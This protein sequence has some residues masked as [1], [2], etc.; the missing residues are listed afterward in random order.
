MSTPVKALLAAAL[1][2]LISASAGAT[3]YT[4]DFTGTVTSGSGVYDTYTAGAAVSGTYYLNFNACMAPSTLPVSQIAYWECESQGGSYEDAP[5]P[6]NAVF[7]SII[8]NASHDTIYQS[9]IGGILEQSTIYG[10]V[11]YTCGATYFA[12][13]AFE[14]E[15]SVAI[16][17]P[18]AVTQESVIDLL[19]TMAPM[20]DEN[21]APILVNANG[22]PGTPGALGSI[23]ASDPSNP[24]SELIFTVGSLTARAAPYININ[25]L[26]LAFSTVVPGTKSAGQ[27]ITVTNTGTA[28]LMISSV[29]LGGANVPSFSITNGC[30]GSLAAGATC[31]INAFFMPAGDGAKSASVNIAS[32]APGSPLMVSLTGTGGIP[33]PAIT[34]SAASLPF[35]TEAL[36]LTTAAQNLILTNSGS[37]PLTVSSVSVAGANPASFS[38]TNGCT[39]SVAVG[40]TCT[41]AVTFHPAGLGAKAGTVVIDSNVADSP[42]V[43][44]LSGTGAA[45]APRITLT[46]PGNAFPPGLAFG[47]QGIGSRSAPL[48]VG[49]KNTGSATLVISSVKLGGANTPSFAVTNGCS[50]SLAVN[51][52]CNISTTFTPGGAGLKSADLIIASNASG[53]ARQIGITGT[54]VVPAPAIA[55]SPASLMFNYEKIGTASGAQT[56]TVTNTGSAAL[57]ISSV[58]L[59]GANQPAFQLNNGCT[60]PVA[61]GNSC[62]ITVTFDSPGAG[63][64]SAQVTITSNAAGSPTIVAMTG[65]SGS[66]GAATFSI[67]AGFLENCAASVSGGLYCWG[68]N[69]NGQVGNGTYTIS[70]PYGISTPVAVVNL[71]GNAPIS[72][73][74]A[75]SVGQYYACALT[76]AGT[77]DCW[78]SGGD[79]LGNYTVS[80]ETDIPVPV[81]N[82]TGSAPLAGI[83]ELAAGNSNSCALT[84]AGTVWCWGDDSAGGL[85]IGIISANSSSAAPQQVLNTSGN[86]PLS[87]IIAISDVNNPCALTNGG[88][89]YCWGANDLGQLGNNST[90]N[91]GLPVAVLNSSG[92]A[93]L[94]DIVSIAGAGLAACAV[95]S[96]GNV[97]CWGFNSEGQLGNGTSSITAVNSLPVQVLDTAGTGP[98]SGIVKVVSESNTFCGLTSTG[99]VYCWGANSF[100][101]LGAGTAG[102]EAPVGLPVAVLNPAGTAP[103]GNIATLTGGE[104]GACAVALTGDVF[105]WGDNTYGELGINTTGGFSDLPVQ[106]LGVGGVGFLQL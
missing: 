56:L 91:S 38:A 85:G 105:C 41:I 60:A 25:A 43:V 39:A 87:G 68:L 26:N 101:G 37:A 50:S 19:G 81:L 83:T 80:T 103:L 99:G 13:S 59:G 30:S 53:P 98:L 15:Y 35:G 1:L 40:A 62:S 5:L 92:S 32:N 11:P 47:N 106:V 33:A 45:D 22:V 67:A 2:G 94:G 21:G 34:T 78:G 28:A 90:T 65:L 8:Y 97:W 69:G 12:Y 93:P 31:T 17:G 71:A 6:T 9:A 61:A 75:V 70:T 27:T 74:T 44:T 89:V 14:D 84:S 20:W 46:I 10:C 100:G 77:A 57:S 42:T 23:I 86:A 24:L 55:V 3:T 4:Y 79:A 16:S 51:A 48:V 66:G 7:A 96:S 104:Y 63:N 64:K 73:I 58:T 95:N 29:T 18:T 54:G 76:S 36:G 88:N 49:V 102:G 72:G 82:S 52:S